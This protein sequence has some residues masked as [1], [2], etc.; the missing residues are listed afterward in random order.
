MGG[1]KSR[2]VLSFLKVSGSPPHGRG[3]VINTNVP[4]HGLGITPAWAGKSRGLRRLRSRSQD[5][6]RMGGEKLCGRYQVR[7]R[8]GSPPHGRGKESWT[9]QVGGCTRITPAWAGKR[10]VLDCC[11]GIVQDHPRMGGEKSIS[12]P[13]FCPGTGSPPHGRG[14]GRRKTL[15]HSTKRI[16]PAWAGKSSNTPLFSR[17]EQDHPRMGGEKIDI[18]AHQDLR[19]GSPPHGRGK[20]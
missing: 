2:L 3:K 6:P 16:T 5:H 20:D 10:A 1:E 12:A 8:H 7:Q 11:A 19:A 9:I 17:R 18:C 4:G 13:S 14:K 15:R